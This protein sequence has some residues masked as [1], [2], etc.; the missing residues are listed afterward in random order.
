MRPLEG[1]ISARMTRPWVEHSIRTATGAVI[2]LLVARSVALPEALLG[3]DHDPH[4]V[5]IHARCR[6]DN[7]R[8]AVRRDRP[9]SCWRGPVDD[10]WEWEYARFWRGCLLAWPYLHASAI[11]EKRVSLCGDHAGDRY[12]DRS[13]RQRVDGGDSPIHRGVDRYRGR[14]GAGRHLARARIT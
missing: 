3:L 4:R 14:F 2:S 11:G 10:I 7:L 13:F 12:A 9:G 1:T 8:P 6:M 5:A